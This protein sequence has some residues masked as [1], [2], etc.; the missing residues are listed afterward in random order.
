MVTAVI[1]AENL[2]RV[3]DKREVINVTFRVEKGSI[4]SFIGP[5]G[6]GKTT[7]IKVIAGLLPKSGGKVEVLGENPWNNPR[8]Y[9]RFSVVFTP[10]HHPQEAKVK[11]YL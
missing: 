7:T 10:I 1:V 3:F 2:T 4:T 8:L 11:E 6:A 5:N 9:E